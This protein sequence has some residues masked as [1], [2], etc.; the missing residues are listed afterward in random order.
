MRQIDKRW[1]WAIDRSG[2]PNVQQTYL[3][4]PHSP[5]IKEMQTNTEGYHSTLPR[6]MQWKGSLSQRQTHCQS[7]C[8]LVQPLWLWVLFSTFFKSRANPHTECTEY[9]V[10]GV[11]FDAFFLHI[12]PGNHYPHQ[13]MDSFQNPTGFHHAPF[14]VIP[15]SLR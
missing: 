15:V 5:T 9:T 13:G 1:E 11:Q 7:G 12:H 10:L 6:Q 14:H 3:K 4:M 8:K 2:S